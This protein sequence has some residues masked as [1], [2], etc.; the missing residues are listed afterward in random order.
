MACI[1]RNERLRRTISLAVQIVPPHGLSFRRAGKCTVR[2]GSAIG[3]QSQ[4][5]LPGTRS[6]VPQ[7]GVVAHARPTGSSWTLHSAPQFEL[8]ASPQSSVGG[9]VS[10]VGLGAI[11]QK[12][13]RLQPH[14]VPGIELTEIL[15]NATCPRSG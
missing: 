1:F 13:P 4:G 10:E 9:Q 2:I 12:S 15:L 7:I 3:A 5:S 11:Q 14:D 8:Q 6:K